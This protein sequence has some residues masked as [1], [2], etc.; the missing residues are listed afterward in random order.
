AYGPTEASIWVAFD[1]IISA[2]DIFI[3]NVVENNKIYVLNSDFEPVGHLQEGELY[4]SGI[5]LFSGYL[6]D[7]EKTEMNL[8]DNIFYDEKHDQKFYQKMYR[9]GD[10]FRKLDNDKYQ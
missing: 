2:N 1:R 7:P 4:I 3:K 8:I 9:T 6:S 5:G 10:R